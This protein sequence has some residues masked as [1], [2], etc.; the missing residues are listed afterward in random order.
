[1]ERRNTNGSTAP[2]VAACVPAPPAAAMMSSWAST[3]S[4]VPALARVGESKVS[5]ISSPPSRS[6]VLGNLVAVAWTKASPNRP[7]RR[8]NPSCGT[9]RRESRMDDSAIA[10]ESRRLDDFVVPLQRQGFGL[11]V[12]QDFQ[13][14]VEVLRI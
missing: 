7:P 13:E 3:M 10:G 1:M 14:R 6:V 9:F 2:P 12:H 4:P 8:G 11:L 5:M